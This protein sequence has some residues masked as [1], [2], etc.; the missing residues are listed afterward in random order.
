MSS[1]KTDYE[2][3]VAMAEEDHRRDCESGLSWTREDWQYWIER[4][5]AELQGVNCEDF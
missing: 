1:C 4:H 3:A 5:F 2:K